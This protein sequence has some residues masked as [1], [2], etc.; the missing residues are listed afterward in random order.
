M[1]QPG[2]VVKAPAL[3]EPVLGNLRRDAKLLPS[4]LVY[5]VGQLRGL[6]TGAVEFRTVPGFAAQEGTKAVLRMDPSARELFQAIGSGRPIGERRCGARQHATRPKRT[7]G[8]RSWTRT[9]ETRPPSVEG[10]L[11]DAGFDVSPGIW[12]ASEAP[13]DIR[14]SRDRI[15]SRGDRATPT[16]S[17]RTSRICARSIADLRGAQV[18]IVSR[19]RTRW[20]PPARVEE[21]PARCPS[22]VVGA[23][24]A[25]RRRGVSSARR[26]DGDLP[27]RRLLGRERPHALTARVRSDARAEA[28]SARRRL[29]VRPSR[30]VLRDRPR[31]PAPPSYLGQRRASEAITG[32]PAAIAS[33]SG[34]P[35]PSYVEG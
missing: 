8:S 21:R 14:R 23:Q 7:R 29:C 26:Y 31:I 27:P 18:A 32:H 1:L 10:V 2:M 13:I 9:P 22:H 11:D 20:C 33:A 3:V 25:A 16:S 5:L 35:K 24:R 15:P 17:R 4:D 19:A 28:S 34:S 12:P 6:S 30:P